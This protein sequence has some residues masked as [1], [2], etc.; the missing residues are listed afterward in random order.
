MLEV[1]N[2]VILSELTDTRFVITSG[3][4]IHSFAYPSLGIKCDGR[5][6]QVSIYVTVPDNFYGQSS[7]IS[8]IFHSSKA[9]VF[10]AVS[11]LNF[12]H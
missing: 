3:E 11:L 6:N 2:R 1:D 10:Q 12:L 8:G 4:T 7:E 9:I 5:L